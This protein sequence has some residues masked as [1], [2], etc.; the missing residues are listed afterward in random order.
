[1]TTLASDLEKLLDK[2]KREMEDGIE[3]HDEF[4]ESYLNNT[5]LLYSYDRTWTKIEASK[6]YETSTQFLRNI[7]N[8]GELYLNGTIAD[9]IN[10]EIELIIYKSSTL[11]RVSPI[12]QIDS[13]QDIVLEESNIKITIPKNQIAPVKGI[14]SIFL[15]SNLTNKFPSNFK[16][17]PLELLTSTVD[18]TLF[19]NNLVNNVKIEFSHQVFDDVQNGFFGQVLLKKYYFIYSLVKIMIKISV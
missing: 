9:G 18:F 2:R 6:G 11:K 3:D 5:D 16:S 4:F 13:Y 1:M 7:I 14:G 19:E 17:T 15:F 10:D 12:Y 8:A